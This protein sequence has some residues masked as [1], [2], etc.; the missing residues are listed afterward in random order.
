M[1]IQ[2]PPQAVNK[3]ENESNFR[4]SYLSAIKPPKK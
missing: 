3:R 4:G 1:V 2:K